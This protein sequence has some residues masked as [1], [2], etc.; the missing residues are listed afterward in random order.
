V[1][2]GVSK[3]RPLEAYW[4]HRRAANIPEQ[5]RD[6]NPDLITAPNFSLFLDAPR[7]DNLQNMKRIAICWNELT[8]QHLPTSLHL[9]A[10]TETDW[11]RLTAFV[12]EREEVQSVAFEFATG[13]AGSRGEWHVEKIVEMATKVRRPLQIV[14]RGGLQYLSSLYPAFAQIVFI[15]TTPFMKTIKRQRAYLKTNERLKWQ[16]HATESLDTL[17]QHNVD[18]CSKLAQR[19]MHSFWKRAAARAA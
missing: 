8:A 1:F 19:A 6:L 18:E 3:D 11:Q 2:S 9:N 14:I 12:A 17:F 16:K 7:W 10:R 5:L 15:D 13:A 4:E